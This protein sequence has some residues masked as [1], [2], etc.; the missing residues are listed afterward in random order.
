MQRA[1]TQRDTDKRLL[2]L[3]QACDR[4]ICA[5]L[6]GPLQVLAVFTWGAFILFLE[7]RVWQSGKEATLVGAVLKGIECQCTS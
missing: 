2:F 7:H 5:I 6:A 1:Q 3:I 4:I